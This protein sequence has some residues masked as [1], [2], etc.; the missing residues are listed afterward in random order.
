MSPS[1]VCHLCPAGLYWELFVIGLVTLQAD[2][3]KNVENVVFIKSVNI[4]VVFVGSFNI[5][6]VFVET[7]N[8]SV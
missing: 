6:V 2:K 1:I 3:A 7:V 4:S 5:S 8:T